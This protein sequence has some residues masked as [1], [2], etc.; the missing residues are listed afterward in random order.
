MRGRVGLDCRVVK[1]RSEH[2]NE[3]AGFDEVVGKLR[4]VV[5]TLEQGNL[6]LEQS[7]QSYEVGVQL[8]RRGHELLDL[9]E[10]RVE[11]LVRNREGLPEAVPFDDGA[12][13]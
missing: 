7:L 5:E 3:G 6:S 4:E 13:E 1:R 9:A 8:A 10:K 12:D 11:L 2:A